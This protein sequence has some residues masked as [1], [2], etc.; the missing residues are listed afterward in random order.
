[1]RPK[2]RWPDAHIRLKRLYEAKVP[3]DVTQ[4]KF[5][6][7][8][9]I[10][11]AGMVW[12]YLSG[13][14]PLNYEAAAKFAK[15][16]GCSIYDI[17]PDMAKALEH[18]ILPFLGRAL[19]R[20]AALACFA[21]LP[22]SM[23]PSGAD[24]AAFL[25]LEQQATV[26]YVNWRSRSRRWWQ[27]IL[28]MLGG[29]SVAA[30]TT[31]DEHT[32]PPKDWPDLSITEHYVPH[33]QMRDRCVKYTAWY[34]NPEACMEVH[35]DTKVCDLWFSADFPP[36]QLFVQHERMHCAGYQHPGDTQLSDAWNNYKA[37]VA[38]ESIAKSVRQRTQ[39]R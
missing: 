10:G 1:M 31:I 16:L 39:S 11:T 37:A 4:E 13:H 34:L 7:D 23:W 5:G 20:A 2:N 35:F 26:Y 38:G 36:P 9:D 3:Q 25:R 19:R 30:C 28:A 21:V 32:E 6:A 27:S 14:R 24:A 29:G 8:N 22:A 18:E 15:G 12:Q 33:A 17:C